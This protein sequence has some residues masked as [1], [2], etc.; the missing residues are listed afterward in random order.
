MR[1]NGWEL[2]LNW[3]DNINDVA[4]STLNSYLIDGFT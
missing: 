1:T 4:G 3:N 2:T